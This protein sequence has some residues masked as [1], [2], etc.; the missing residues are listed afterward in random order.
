MVST[1]EYEIMSSLYDDIMYD[2][3]MEGWVSDQLNKKIDTSSNDNK[4]SKSIFATAKETKEK[5]DNISKIF[6]FVFKL[7]GGI[8]NVIKGI[9]DYKKAGAQTDDEKAKT[10]C[11]IA[12]KRFLGPALKK[13]GDEW[14]ESEI[15]KRKIL[16]NIISVV[17]G[18]AAGIADGL[19]DK[20]TRS[21]DNV[22]EDAKREISN[23]ESMMRALSGKMDEKYFGGKGEIT[24]G[25]LADCFKMEVMDLFGNDILNSNNKSQK[26]LNGISDKI[27]DND[28]P[29][30][31]K[32]FK[33][34]TDVG[35]KVF[36]VAQLLAAIGGSN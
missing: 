30:I 1:R 13:I 27:S 17:G 18:G 21:L 31:I 19:M 4:G 29:K 8:T 20:Q 14:K 10:I 26:E 15:Q 7:L 32:M 24:Y 6:K 35:K 22:I 11:K 9:V 3:A 28:D 23:A 36:T 16:G 25:L 12:V 34:A 5:I 33:D 2:R